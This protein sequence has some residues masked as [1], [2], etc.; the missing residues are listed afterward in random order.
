MSFNVTVDVKYKGFG[1]EHT[2]S[3][4]VTGDMGIEPVN[5]ALPAATTVATWTKSDANT[6]TATLAAEHGLA[7][8]TY[9]V[10][11]AAGIRYGVTVTITENS[12][13]LEGGEGVDFPA[14][15]TAVNIAEQLTIP[16][17][18]DGDNLTMISVLST[19]RANVVFQTTGPT[20]YLAKELTANA[21]FGWDNDSG[22]DNPLSEGESTPIVSIVASNGETSA[23]VLDMFGLQNA[24]E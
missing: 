21:A 22:A 4:T 14:S 1:S 6:A 5:V 8:G 12:V 2:R 16:S 24:V 10:Y 18:F 13:A 23:G 3:S 15:E 7:S 19:V 17:E 11:W 20:T 9:D